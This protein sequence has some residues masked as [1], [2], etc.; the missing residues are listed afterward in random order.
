MS[1]EEGEKAGKAFDEGVRAGATSE[2]ESAEEES[3]EE[4]SA[5][6]SAEEE[7]PLS[8]SSWIGEKTGIT[9]IAEGLGN[10][11]KVRDNINSKRA[12]QEAAQQR[13]NAARENAY[14]NPEELKAAR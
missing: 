11:K 14:K 10:K 9:D 7:S 3:A 4:E 1:R 5:E 6:E 12:A 13:Y 8:L 2:E